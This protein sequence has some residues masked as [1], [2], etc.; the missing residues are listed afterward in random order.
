MQY[1]HY[2][3]EYRIDRGKNDKEHN[4]FIVNGVY[5]LA[6]F[7]FS[8]KS[9][10]IN[11]ARSSIPLI[12]LKPLNEKA[13]SVIIFSH[14]N[15]SDL[16]QCIDVI[17]SLAEIHY[18]TFIAYDY[19]GYGQ[20]SIKDATSQTICDDLETLIAW[21]NVPLHHL[22]LV[23]FSLGCY[24]TAKVA[25]NYKVKAVLLISPMLSLISLLSEQDSLGVNTFFK[26]D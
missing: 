25:S 17:C 23:G 6:P 10:I 11:G 26:Q 7:G 3:L 12:K 9:Y 21:L 13:N 22:V 19:T 8:L 14:G 1:Y 18:A 4:T 16:S 15:G 24:P 5:Y 2:Q 20:S